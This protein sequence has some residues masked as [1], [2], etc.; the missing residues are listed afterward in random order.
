M[1]H[2]MSNYTSLERRLTAL[3]ES[4][5]ESSV[6]IE[7]AIMCFEV[8]SEV[9]NENILKALAMRTFPRLNNKFRQNLETV[10]AEFQA[11][12]EKPTL[13]PN[14]PEQSG[15]V[16]WARVCIN[17]VRLPFIKLEALYN[18]YLSQ[19]V[20]EVFEQNKLK[21]SQ[22]VSIVND[23]E[24]QIYETWSQQ[25][26]DKCIE[27][28]EEFLLRRQ[29]IQIV[30]LPQS[31]EVEQ[32]EN[33]GYVQHV[34]YEIKQ[35][36]K[37]TEQ[38][39]ALARNYSLD[40]PILLQT[41]FSQELFSIL[42]ETKLFKILNKIIPEK[43]QEVYDKGNDYRQLKN[44]LDDIV[45][46]YNYVQKNL[47]YVERPLFYSQI[48]QI[49]QLLVKG[50]NELRW[51][52]WKDDKAEVEQFITS[53]KLPISVLYSQ[54][55][56]LKDQLS[57]TNG[58]LKSWARQPL[59][60]KPQKQVL[61]LD[62]VLQLINTKIQSFKRENL[63]KFKQNKDEVWD[64]DVEKVNVNVS[65]AKNAVFLDEVANLY[66][67]DEQG[68]QMAM[69]MQGFKTDEQK[70]GRLKQ[71]WDAYLVWL[72]Q[73]IQ[74]GLL[75]IIVQNII[76]IQQ[77]MDSSETTEH[78]DFYQQNMT[79]NEQSY[80][81]LEI[82]MNIGH[83][84]LYFEPECAEDTQSTVQTLVSTI[85]GWITQ[86]CKVCDIVFN[87]ITSASIDSLRQST[88]RDFAGLIRQDQRFA[89]A[90]Q[91]LIERV[92]RKCAIAVQQTQIMDEFTDIYKTDKR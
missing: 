58:L 56:T 44:Q 83:Q 92:R 90:N 25:V 52:T 4:A 30:G 41:N 18:A 34:R 81:F 43:A 76:N 15:R 84:R 70:I 79:P 27:K 91:M 21:Y 5:V 78:N 87:P 63:T 54:V 62:K 64:V 68:R 16:F 77:Y 85:Q 26:N 1:T 20:D 73:Y 3:L 10:V 32:D 69:Q 31:H 29:E 80:P 7:Q 42:S 65:I 66:Q 88:L 89:E 48:E 57:Q 11:Q 67:L 61:Q 2:F 9:L 8:F 86:I 37:V 14:M 46:K 17:R 39:L 74:N 12:K 49:E 82:N 38:E 47:F 35:G 19:E 13:E 51:T 60:E 28:L 72:S 75:Q 23:Y 40:K 50:T 55:I 36:E 22:F 53:I 59:I 45:N 24:K 33:G 6:S 71:Y